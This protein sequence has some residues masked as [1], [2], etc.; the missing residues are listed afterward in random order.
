MK[1]KQYKMSKE[2]KLRRVQK[3]LSEGFQLDEGSIAPFLIDPVPDVPQ[4]VDSVT[5]VPVV[6]APPIVPE[7]I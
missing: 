7:N 4:Q 2:E 1:L 6:D 3:L 5:D